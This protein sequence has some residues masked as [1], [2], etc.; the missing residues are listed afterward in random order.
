MN[1]RESQNS[2]KK[3]FFEFL[4][5]GVTPAPV[6]TA[7]MLKNFGEIIFS[8]ILTKIGIQVEQKRE[9]L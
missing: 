6:C 4:R 3:T 7:E 1:R 9:S 2:G 5:T 8:K